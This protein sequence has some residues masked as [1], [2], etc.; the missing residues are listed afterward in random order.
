MIDVLEQRTQPGARLDIHMLQ[1]RAT[2]PWYQQ[3]RASLDAQ[4]ANFY[5]VPGSPLGP[6]PARAGAFRLGNA[7]YVA[8]VDDDDELAPSAAEVA[9]AYLD[10]HPEVVAIYSNIDHYSEDWR[11]IR[12]T[13][14]LEWS[15][16]RMI[17]KITETLHWGVWRR[18]VIAPYVAALATEHRWADWYYLNCM[19]ALHGPLARLPEPLYRWRRKPA[20]N[21]GEH[22]ALP[23]LAAVIR[24]AG[25]LLTKTR[26]E[27][28]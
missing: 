24:K 6:G 16:W 13:D 20:G 19:A 17:H 10:A 1:L 12:R 4:A 9:V 8:W 3:A 25:P 5:I 2:E 28:P 11:F 14:R 26:P 18:A 21:C 27:E 7:P 15:A 22:I 23:E